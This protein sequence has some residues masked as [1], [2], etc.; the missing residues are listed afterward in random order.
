VIS[1]RALSVVI[2]QGS[3]DVRSVIA[4]AR[5][6]LA[7]GALTTVLIVAASEPDRDSIERLALNE[8]LKVG[9]GLDVTVLDD[10][11]SLSGL[12][13]ACSTEFVGLVHPVDPQP[14]GVLEAH[15]DGLRAC[16]EAVL[17][18]SRAVGHG[19]IEAS[20][21]DERW[22][23]VGASEFEPPLID[24]RAF[25]RAL[26]IDGRPPGM[27]F[28]F[29]LRAN[30][31][32]LSSSGDPTDQDAGPYRNETD[33]YRLLLQ[34]LIRGPVWTDPR[35][36]VATPSTT[37]RETESTLEYWPNVIDIGVALGLLDEPGD[38]A[39]ALVNHTRR[40]AS[41]LKAHLP[42]DPSP[43]AHGRERLVRPI[44]ASWHA[45]IADEALV[46]ALLPLHVA[47]VGDE[48]DPDS[49]TTLDEARTIAQNVTLFRERG[50]QHADLSTLASPL[51][52]TVGTDDI[53]GLLGQHPSYAVLLARAGERLEVLDGRQ[54]RALLEDEV[55]QSTSDLVTPAGLQ[56]RLVWPRRSAYR[57][58]NTAR[59]RS[60]HS[61]Q[62]SDLRKS[63][64]KDW[65]A[66]STPS[67]H[68]HQLRKFV[69]A[70]PEYT[71]VHGGVVA[72]HR[73]CDRLNAIGYE[74]Y[75]EPTGPSSDTRPGWT[76]PLR[77]GRSFNDSVVIYPEVVSGNP[78][79][80][81]R[82]VRWLLNRPGWFTGER[83]EESSEDLVVAFD[84]QI[85][86]DHAVLSVPLIDPTL[87]FPKDRPGKGGLLWIGKGTLSSTFDRSD[88]TLITNMW[89]RERSEL[90]SL[91]RAA[92]VLYTCDW[93]TS[94]I[95]E[96]LMCATPV[97][98]IGDQAWSR[99][100]VELKPG[101]AWED[102]TDLRDARQQATRYF[103]DYLETLQRT[104]NSIEQ[105]VQ[106]VNDHFC[107]PPGSA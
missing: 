42:D 38:L 5:S 102:E 87:F 22:P 49:A 4:S 50:S 90:A 10:S 47:V 6:S 24:G 107:S 83:M 2:C 21:S 53:D 67:P 77:R 73:L 63:S 27:P 61:L 76:T 65:M 82:V 59:T 16:P 88:T 97:V 32:S 79:S 86:P 74:A 80:A 7:E 1:S 29:V 100:D 98:L 106:L 84:H 34:I 60:V 68:P 81:P 40:A 93:L 57:G 33:W 37:R 19:F 15:V 9:P 52:E 70:A 58:D 46:P 26:L 64:N 44:I 51:G 56:S 36:P 35:P 17:A 39:I 104:D 3:A 95:A 54:I 91:L 89:P 62:L 25:A 101:M 45:L 103:P 75:L 18:V 20:D 72:L 41:F 99:E 14:L 11:T 71:E 92:D 13:S 96:A 23:P 85:S 30:A 43:S 55:S 28:L 31:M 105:F 94:V 69:I 12:L 66:E 8:H 78:F 48:G